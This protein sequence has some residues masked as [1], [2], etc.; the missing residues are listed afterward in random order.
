M[1]CQSR[2]WWGDSSPGDIL[3]HGDRRRWVQDGVVCH[4]GAAEVAR[5]CLP[6]LG[7][8]G[9]L[10]PHAG[11]LGRVFTHSS[12]LTPSLGPH[13]LDDKVTVDLGKQTA[14]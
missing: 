2:L 12:D 3:V 14:L 11:H 9:A 6:I 13:H 10:K 5:K 4:M 1:L 8:G 7:A